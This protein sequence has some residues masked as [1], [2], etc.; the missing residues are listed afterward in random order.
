MLRAIIIAPVVAALVAVSAGAG[1]GWVIDAAGAAG[2][3]AAK[4]ITG[5]QIKDG[6]VGSKDLSKAVRSALSASPGAGP[7]LQGPAGLDGE[8]GLDGETIV[9]PPGPPGE[10]GTAAERGDP[11]PPGPMGP[12][13]PV[14]FDLETLASASAC[15]GARG[16]SIR[17]VWGVENHQDS[18]VV[19]DGPGVGEQGPPGP[20]G[21]RG[22]QGIPGQDGED[23]SQGPQGEQGPP[24]ERGA[25][26]PAGPTGP[27]GPKGDPGT[28]GAGISGRWTGEV[29]GSAN[30]SV[31][32]VTEACAAVASVR[33]GSTP[34]FA[35][36]RVTP[37][38]V[39]VNV[40]NSNGAA[41][42]ATVDLIVSC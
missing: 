41:G 11:G 26:G 5:A 12:E 30:V 14:F 33:S 20:Q 40:W 16:V 15:G 32:G 39:A 31:P 19:C 3:K 13:S 27:Q 37:G 9:G 21:E 25:T 2:G 22:P 38:V 34:R 24:G 6:T 8:D 1:P 28:P 4:L 35:T 23:G 42:G 36:T 17:A 10:P 29:D 7:G 18:A